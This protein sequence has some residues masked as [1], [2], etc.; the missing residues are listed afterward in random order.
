VIGP[1]IAQDLDVPVDD[2][3][4]QVVAASLTAAFNLLSEGSDGSSTKQDD[5]AKAIDPVITFM[6]GGLE[7]LK[8]PR[9]THR[10]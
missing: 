2:P 1:A 7:A 10:R 6:R 5:I 9:T 8:E 3:R 4:T